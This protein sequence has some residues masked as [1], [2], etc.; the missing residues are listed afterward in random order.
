M[1]GSMGRRDRMVRIAWMAGWTGWLH[2]MA[3]GRTSWIVVRRNGGNRRMHRPVLGLCECVLT[4]CPPLAAALPQMRTVKRANWGATTGFTRSRQCRR[5]ART[6]S[7][8]SGGHGRASSCRRRI[9]G[10]LNPASAV[11]MSLKETACLRALALEPWRFAALC[12]AVVASVCP[13]P[14]TGYRRDSAGI[15]PYKR[16]HVMPPAMCAI[17]A[18]LRCSRI[19]Q[20]HDARSSDMCDM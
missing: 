15:R 17:G 5:D 10:S 3:E 7:G 14:A 2:R 20:R 8:M 12:T 1:A 19:L 18:F 16:R 4:K 13:L 11:C 9:P 6:I